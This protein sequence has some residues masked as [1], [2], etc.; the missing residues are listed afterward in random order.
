ME[1]IEQQNSVIADNQSQMSHVIEQK[2]KLEDKNKLLMSKQTELW[3]NLNRQ[4][5]TAENEHADLKQ[6]ENTSD[7]QHAAVKQRENI[8]SFTVAVIGYVV[9]IAHG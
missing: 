3:Q 2:A 8:V 4:E 6:L 1:K 9:D 5:N 7:K